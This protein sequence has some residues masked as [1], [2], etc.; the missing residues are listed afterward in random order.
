M[1]K[2][3]KSIHIFIIVVVL[4]TLVAFFYPIVEGN[5]GRH[6]HHHKTP[7]PTVN[8]NYQSWYQ[9]NPLLAN[10][11]TSNYEGSNVCDTYYQCVSNNGADN[12]KAFKG[13]YC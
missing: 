7:T 2:K 6:H 11:N 12:C 13:D 9:P 10:Y 1:S 8:V 5:Q 3:I 4:V